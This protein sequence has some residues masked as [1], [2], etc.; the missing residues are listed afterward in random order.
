MNERTEPMDRLRI[1][2]E[3]A[4]FWKIMLLFIDGSNVVVVDDRRARLELKVGHNKNA[5]MTPP[6]RLIVYPL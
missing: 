5:P 4:V 3:Y 1:V 2:L 6:Y